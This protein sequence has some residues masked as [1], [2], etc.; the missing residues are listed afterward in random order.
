MMKICKKCGETKNESEFYRR[1][2][3]WLMGS[4][5]VCTFAQIR[6]ARI[7]RMANPTLRDKSNASGRERARRIKLA[8]LAVYGNA[9][10][11]CGETEITF[12]SIDH[13]DNNG[14]AHR[15]DT[16][17][18]SG[19]KFYRWLI[20]NE[21][22]EGFQT[23]CMNCQFGKAQNKGVCPHQ[24]RRNDY[25]LAGVGSSEPKRTASLKLVG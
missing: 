18:S 3:R 6:A 12:L 17:V 23:L 24:A 22:P 1:D 10:A 9:C 8:V 13:V 21:F 25:P 7:K 15:R 4:C 11:C 19:H 16:G 20:R 5:K 2:N 14:A